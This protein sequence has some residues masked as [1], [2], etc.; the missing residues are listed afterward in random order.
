MQVEFDDLAWHRSQ[1]SPKDYYFLR[2]FLAINDF[3]ISLTLACKTSELTLLGFI[4][5][6]VG[7][8][9]AQGYV[10]KYL[11]D[12]VC[13]IA[14]ARRYI[15]HTPDAAFALEKEGKAALFFVEIDRELKRSINRMR[16]F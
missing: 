4:P 16:G 5:E 3:R 8:K 6:Y 13:D 11:R 1:R 2:H 15:S 10:K 12:K 7:E 14:N 9:T